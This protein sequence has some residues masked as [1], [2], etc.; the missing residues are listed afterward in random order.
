[1]NAVEH[2]IAARYQSLRSIFV[3]RRGTRMHKSEAKVAHESAQL[4]Q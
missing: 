4:K 3:T 2:T 1:M